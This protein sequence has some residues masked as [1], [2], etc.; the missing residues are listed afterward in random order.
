MIYLSGPMSGLP[1]YNWPTI[2]A[3]AVALR[4]AGHTVVNPAETPLPASSDYALR[5]PTRPSLPKQR[6]R[7]LRDYA[8]S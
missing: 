7:K 3:A 4:S 5:P 2:D 8:G 1:D 6:P